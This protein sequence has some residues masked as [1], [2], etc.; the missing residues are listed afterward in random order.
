MIRNLV[1][2]STDIIIL[3]I[4][5]GVTSATIA[6]AW[7]GAQV[8]LFWCRNRK[9]NEI[10]FAGYMVMLYGTIAAASIALLLETW[11]LRLIFKV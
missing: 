5:L 7:L 2:Q 4:W 9:E 11:T 8:I 1:A 3:I 6:V 10:P